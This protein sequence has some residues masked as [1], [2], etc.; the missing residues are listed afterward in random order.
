M[1]AS[2][3]ASLLASAPGSRRCLATDLRSDGRDLRYGRE[4]PLGQRRRPRWSGA[5]RAK[6]RSKPAGVQTISVRAA[7]PLWLANVCVH[8]AR[9]EGEFARAA[10]EELVAELEGQLAVEHPEELVEVVMVQARAREA[11]PHAVLHHRDPPPALLAAHE[12]VDPPVAGAIGV[13]AATS[14]RSAIVRAD[15]RH[16]RRG[17]QCPRGGSSAAACAASGEVALE[18][19]R[20]AEQQ[21]ARRRV[22]EVRE[23]VRDA[24]G[25]EGERPRPGG[26]EL[27]AELEGQLAVEDVERLVE[28]VVVQRRALPAARARVFSTAEIAPAVCSP[29]SSTVVLNPEA[30]GPPYDLRLS[31]CRGSSGRRRTTRSASAA[32]GAATR[33]TAWTPSMTSARARA[34][35]VRAGSRR[36]HGAEDGGARPRRRA[37]G[38]SRSWRS[39]RRARADRRCSARPRRGPG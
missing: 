6:W 30:I 2:W 8:A 38:R 28:R 35:R 34:R 31:V 27:V 12:D 20:R 5:I 19:R 23:R 21:V 11:R 7:A 13:A 16:R 10:R 29:R 9:R 1:I 33:K 32:S 17:R 39:R 15:G 14:S 22:A 26:E 36:E 18:A 4:R 25:R 24:A 37:R 3:S